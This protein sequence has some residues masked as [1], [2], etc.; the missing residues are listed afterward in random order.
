MLCWKLRR[1]TGSTEQL[2]RQLS[3][4]LRQAPLLKSFSQSIVTCPR[5]PGQQAGEAGLAQV[6]GSRT[7]GYKHRGGQACGQA[8]PVLLLGPFP[9][10]ETGPGTRINKPKATEL[11]ARGRI[12][13]QVCAESENNREAS[14]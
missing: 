10:D 4:Q 8:R 5:S 13:S 14:T 2:P 9:K 6:S 11:R 7:Q 3:K 1:A 12:R